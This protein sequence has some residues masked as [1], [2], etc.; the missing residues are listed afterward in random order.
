MGWS[1]ARAF[2]AKVPGWFMTQMKAAHTNN[3]DAPGFWTKLI[4]ILLRAQR[5]HVIMVYLNGLDLEPD[6]V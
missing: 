4:L 5:H 1:L 6:R 3:L 2:R